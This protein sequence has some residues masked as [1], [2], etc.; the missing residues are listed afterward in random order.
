MST[1]MFSVSIQ[2]FILLTEVMTSIRII[3]LM[4]NF[5]FF[6]MYNRHTLSIN[7]QNNVVRLHT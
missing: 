3:D 6:S 4:N 5:Y 2:I 1:E 7:D